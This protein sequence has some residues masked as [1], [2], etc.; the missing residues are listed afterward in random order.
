VRT[1]SMKVLFVCTGNICRSPIAER[2][3]RHRSAQLGLDLSVS[4]AGT[5]ALN[6]KP[7]HPESVRVL[8]ERGVDA[9]DFFSRLLTP[10]MVSSSDLILGLTRD[11]RAAARQLAPVRWRRMYALREMKVGESHWG[12]ANG[13]VRASGGPLD[14]TDPG[15][16]IEDP[17][18]RSAAVFDSVAED[19][20][21]TMDVLVT[22][23]E[24]QLAS[25][26]PVQ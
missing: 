22:W 6:G 10:V 21:S 9:A 26:T 5:R 11:H 19:I 4:S 13:D 17:I 25:F 3:L 12:T 18:G 15:L 14:P 1:E 20:E 23:I 7:M 2:L 8:Q 16:D 24:H